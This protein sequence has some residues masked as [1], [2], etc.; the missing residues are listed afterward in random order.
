MQ[1]LESLL[2]KLAQQSSSSLEQF[3]GDAEDQELAEHRLQFAAQ[4]CID[5]ANYLLARVPAPPAQRNQ[6]LFELL[7]EADIIEVDLA[8]RLRGLVGFRNIL[9][10]G[11]LQVD[12]ATVYAHLTERLDDFRAFAR[13]TVRLA[14]LDED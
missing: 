1:R 12:P 11:D 2:V 6:N 5:I 10:H 14:D 9:V 7:A 4:I 3:L 8:E 13:A